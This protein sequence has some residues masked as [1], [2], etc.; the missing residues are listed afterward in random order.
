MKVVEGDILKG[1]LRFALDM[2]KQVLKDRVTLTVL[3]VL[4]ITGEGQ[5]SPQGDMAEEARRVKR[6][7]RKS[8]SDPTGYWDLV[9]GPY[10]LTYNETVHIP[11]GGSLILQPHETLDGLA[12]RGSTRHSRD[13][14]RDLFLRGDD[15]AHDRAPGNE[16]RMVVTALRSS[17]RPLLGPA[18]PA[19]FSTCF[20]PR[21]RYTRHHGLRQ[22]DYFRCRR[23]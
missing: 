19:R 2:E 6:P 20:G 16:P 12:V 3:D 10:W 1:S 13:R 5:I 23:S 9:Q 11:G 8:T 14:E 4:Q 22:H 18:D 21:D 15:V 17:K 7:A